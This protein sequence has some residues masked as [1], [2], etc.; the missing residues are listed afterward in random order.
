MYR[1]P[2]HTRLI[3]RFLRP[4]F[5]SLFHLL[6]RVRISGLEN[7]PKRGAYVVAVNHISIFEPPLI[8]AFWP[9]APEAAAAVEIWER[10]GQ[11]TLVRLYGAIRVHRGEYDRELVETTTAALR[12]GR[13]L[14]IFPEGG[15]THVPGLRR[16]LPGVAYLIDKVQAHVIPVGITGTT[17]DFLKRAIRGNRPTLEIRI[18]RPFTLP[19]VTG[20]GEERRVSR[21]RNADLVMAHIAALL[22][23]EYRGVYAETNFQGLPA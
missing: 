8:L 10:R 22:P 17:D 4:V 5:R 21:Q 15:R 16:A 7:V 12:S 2:F 18:G 9:A 20:K 14:V 13:P 11:A 1:I 6:S 3:R 23:P 19:P